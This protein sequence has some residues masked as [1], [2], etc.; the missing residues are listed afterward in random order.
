MTAPAEASRSE[1]IQI[2]IR[3]SCAHLG[4]RLGASRER[5][6]SLD[7]VW[8]WAWGT[9]LVV[10]VTA[11]FFL[12]PWLSTP[13][14]GEEPPLEPLPLSVIWEISDPAE[15][16]E[17]PAIERATPDAAIEELPMEESP[18]S[19]AVPEEID[20]TVETPDADISE[21]SQSEPEAESPEPQSPEP[22]NAEPELQPLDPSD[23]LEF[24]AEPPVDEPETDEPEIDEEST[25][26]EEVV[27]DDGVDTNDFNPDDFDADAVAALLDA[28][29]DEE[30]RRSREHA[31]RAALRK[32]LSKALQV[33]HPEQVGH[34]LPGFVLRFRI[35]TEG[36]ILD[37]VLRAP[38]HV[39]PERIRSTI[40]S[41]APLDPP[42]I[43]EG[44]LQ[45]EHLIEF[46][47]RE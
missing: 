15:F 13:L 39:V 18:E 4:R 36:R 32:R 22:Q 33:D 41:L 3:E 6:N 9:S 40:L 28:V 19:E 27:E 34:D 43:E 21:P 45:I 44:T 30:K 29:E 38:D 31:Y 23:V 14:E 42:P 46:V 5:W 7:P 37:L 1:R 8:R 35:D 17:P 12:V 26:T 11:T 10:H 25:P 47:D 16:S 2:A 24:N 20:A